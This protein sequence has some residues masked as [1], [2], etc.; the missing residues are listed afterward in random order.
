MTLIVLHQYIWSIKPNYLWLLPLISV[1]SLL[2]HGG[3]VKCLDLELALVWII[4][5]THALV[6]S[7]LHLT[8]WENGLEF[9]VL[10]CVWVVPLHVCPCTMCTPVQF[11]GSRNCIQWWGTMWVLGLNPA[12][13]EASALKHWTTSPDRKCVLLAFSLFLRKPIWILL[14]VAYITVS[15]Q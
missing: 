2:L 7:N 11:P 1:Q 8:P 10:L 4:H 6:F 5:T 13:L 3:A 15:L 9:Y 12:P 14:F